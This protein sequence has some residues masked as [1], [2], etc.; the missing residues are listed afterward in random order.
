MEYYLRSKKTGEII[1]CVSTQKPDFSLD[2][3]ANGMFKEKYYL[4]SNPPHDV[5]MRYQYYTERP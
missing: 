4:D 1:N 2:T 5:L 3:F